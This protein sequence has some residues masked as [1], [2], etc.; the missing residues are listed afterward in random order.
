MGDQIHALVKND[1]DSL[2]TITQ[3]QVE[4]YEVLNGLEIAF[5][6]ELNNLYDQVD[7]HEQERTVSKLMK[8]LKN[9]NEDLNRLRD[10]LKEQVD[11]TQKYK[12]Q[13]MEL[14]EFA[15]EHNSGTLKEVYHA[16]NDSSA[17]Y[18]QEGRKNSNLR[19]VVINRK[20]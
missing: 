4:R 17:H 5:K 13:L 7:T 14:L 10:N 15:K 9:P 1:L 3:H 11:L 8:S 6:D 2:N 18:T 16:V 20:A 19:S 12:N